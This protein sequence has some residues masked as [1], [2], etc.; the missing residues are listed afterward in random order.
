LIEITTR[1]EH[2]TSM[3]IILHPSIEINLDEGDITNIDEKT[4]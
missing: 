3:D 1:K 4:T 2:E